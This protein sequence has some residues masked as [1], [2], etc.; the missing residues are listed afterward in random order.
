MWEILW[1]HFHPPREWL[2]YLLWP[3]S[4]HGVAIFTPKHWREI[5][6]AFRE[7]FRLSLSTQRRRRELGMNALE[8][9]LLL[10]EADLPYAAHPMDDRIRA[11][12]EHIHGHLRQP[13]TLESLS[14]IVH[15]S[16]SRF[17]HLFR[18]EIGMPPLQYVG[19]QRVHRAQTLLERT[20]MSVSEIAAE[21]GMEPFHFSTHFKTHT[22]ISP[23]AYRTLSFGDG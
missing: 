19:L 4:A 2:E 8:R 14:G 21:V 11:V 20:T 5:H 1:V 12:V 13:L 23:R 17:A 18:K 10:C 3:P 6:A 22:G 9:L 16:H 7:A 15:L